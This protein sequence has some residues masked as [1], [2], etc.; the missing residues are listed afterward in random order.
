MMMQEE[1]CPKAQIM[2]GISMNRTLVRLSHEIIEKNKGVENVL[3][4]GVIR[5]GVTLAERISA[6]IEKIEGK[7]V[8]VGSLDIR[9][10][11]DD[12]SGDQ[13]IISGTELPFDIG[14]KTVIL[15]DDV[16]FTGRT[17][18]AAME[19]LFE[20]GRPAAIQLAVLVDRGLRELP[21]KPDYTGKNIPTSHRELVD[22]K[23]AEIDGEDSVSI[24]SKNS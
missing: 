22:V 11:R 21:V 3:L 20:H 14:G 10:H 15:V 19:A 17:V 24:L 4:V 16:I 2:D 18:R 6:N 9:F 13:P 5:R 8:S 12:F 1:Y 23:V 7:R